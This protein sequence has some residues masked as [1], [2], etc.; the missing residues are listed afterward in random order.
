M[1][2]AFFKVQEK[3]NSHPQNTLASFLNAAG[4]IGGADETR[5]ITAFQT[6]LVAAFVLVLLSAA[7]RSVRAGDRLD[8]FITLYLL[9]FWLFSL[10]VVDN[11]F[12]LYRHQAMPLPGVLLLRHVR[13]AAATLSSSSSRCSRS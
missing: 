6:I 2:D 12:G 11:G 8:L 9:A 10:S 3:Y 4:Q 1:W 7:W 13:P 5:R